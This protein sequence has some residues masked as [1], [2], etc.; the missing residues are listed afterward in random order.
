MATEK[1]AAEFATAERR[2]NY[3]EGLKVELAGVKGRGDEARENAIKTEIQRVAGGRNTTGSK[4]T[5]AST[6]PATT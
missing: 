3:L 6:P 4:R 1:K 2:K 5:T